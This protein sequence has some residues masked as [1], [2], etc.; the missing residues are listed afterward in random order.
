MYIHIFVWY[1][2]RSELQ[3]LDSSAYFLDHL[4][5]IGAANYLPSQVTAPITPK[6]PYIYIDLCG[7]FY[8]TLLTWITYM[9]Y[10][11]EDYVRCRLRTSGM[12][13]VSLSPIALSLHHIN[14]HPYTKKSIY[15]HKTWI[16]WN[17][18][19]CMLMNVLC[20]MDRH[21]GEESACQWC[22]IHLYRCW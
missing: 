1:V 3:L 9:V 10:S 5:I 18:E 8:M 15:R 11:Q 20:L 21:S 7:T 2:Y 13:N 14:T 4:D 17:L 6:Q 19:R 12:Y 16:L 22:P